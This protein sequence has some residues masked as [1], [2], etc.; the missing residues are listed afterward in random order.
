MDVIDCE[1]LCEPS[2]GVSAVQCSLHSR[3]VGVYFLP[4]GNAAPVA[5]TH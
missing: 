5:E 2:A 3:A 4:E 1:V